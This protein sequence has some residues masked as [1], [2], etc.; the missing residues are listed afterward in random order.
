M[1]TNTIADFSSLILFIEAPP[2]GVTPWIL[3]AEQAFRV[4]FPPPFTPH[5]KRLAGIVREPMPMGDYSVNIT[6]LWPSESWHVAKGFNIQT[7]GALGSANN[8][9]AILQ[10]AFGSA[11]CVFSIIFYICAKR[12]NRR[13]AAHAAVPSPILEY[14]MGVKTFSDEQGKHWSREAPDSMQNYTSSPVTSLAADYNSEAVSNWG[15]CRF[16]AE[17]EGIRSCRDLS[18]KQYNGANYAERYES[19]MRCPSVEEEEE[20]GSPGGTAVLSGDR[21]GSD[22]IFDVVV[23]CAEQPSDLYAISV[24]P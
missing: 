8:A 16:H 7:L 2:P 12:R 22:E 21:R 20:Y 11:L 15:N 24:T 23:N 14:K 10:I 1:D 6:N 19:H 13:K 9:F 3:P 4:W 5:F 18:T 17:G